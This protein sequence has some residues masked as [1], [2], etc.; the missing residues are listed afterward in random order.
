MLGK[1]LYP[2]AMNAFVGQMVI[3]LLAVAK[4]TVLFHEIM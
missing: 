2:P 1:S 4:R 3:F